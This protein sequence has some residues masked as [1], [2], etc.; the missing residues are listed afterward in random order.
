MEMELLPRQFEILKLI[1]NHYVN[2]NNQ[3]AY[4]NAGGPL[5]PPT[6][7]FI[8]GIHG[9]SI[10]IDIAPSSQFGDAIITV[11]NLANYNA[12]H[13]P[14]ALFQLPL[15][16]AITWNPTDGTVNVEKLS[17][18]GNAQAN[19]SI[20][21]NGTVSGYNVDANFVNVVNNVTAGGT[22]NAAYVTAGN[23][24]TVYNSATVQNSL[25]AGSLATT[26]TATPTTSATVTHTVPIVIG[27]TTYNLMLS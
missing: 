25:T 11:N 5:T 10:F 16:Q 18:S 24:L 23:I 19:G 22:V 1:N 27:G 4:R 8:G 20:N 12:D 2:S 9:S 26:Q 21:A 3:Q 14:I 17:I 6:A 15:R 7:V 13:G